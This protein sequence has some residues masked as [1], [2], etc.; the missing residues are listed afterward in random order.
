MIDIQHFPGLPWALCIGFPEMVPRKQFYRVPG[1]RNW[2]KADSPSQVRDVRFSNRPVRVKHFQ[3]IHHIQLASVHDAVR[4]CGDFPQAHRESFLPAPTVAIASVRASTARW[5][6]MSAFA[7]AMCRSVSVSCFFF[8]ARF[9]GGSPPQFIAL[10]QV[11]SI[12][13]T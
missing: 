10:D 3:A 11:A 8:R 4:T 2:H 1:V 5:R 6:A 13:R 9:I 7:S 12:L